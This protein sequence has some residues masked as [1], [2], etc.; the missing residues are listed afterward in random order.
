MTHCVSCF[1]PL[2]YLEME[3]G[4][5]KC[6]ILGICFNQSMDRDHLE[7]HGDDHVYFIV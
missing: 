7:C 6:Y 4:H 1:T 5:L 3:M 2:L